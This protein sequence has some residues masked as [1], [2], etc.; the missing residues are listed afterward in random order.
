MVRNPRNSSVKSILCPTRNVIYLWGCRWFY[1]NSFLK[2]LLLFGWWP[3]L[4][5]C[6]TGRI[7]YC[8]IYSSA[9]ITI[10]L[11]FQFLYLC[12]P[13][14]QNCSFFLLYSLYKWNKGTSVIHNWM[15]SLF[16]DFHPDQRRYNS[17]M[18][19]SLLSFFFKAHNCTSRFRCFLSCLRFI[20]LVVWFMHHLIMFGLFSY[21][22]A[23]SIFDY[24]YRMISCLKCSCNC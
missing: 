21:I 10:M 5:V 8:S 24:N 3:L 2:K 22:W 4:V 14:W 16:L 15:D 12:W 19:F 20:V 6:E 9:Y 23:L 18:M 11:H 17:S 1:R 7:L 13:Q